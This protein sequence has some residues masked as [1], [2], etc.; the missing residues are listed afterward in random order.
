MRLCIHSTLF[1]VDMVDFEQD[2]K[3]HL[4]SKTPKKHTEIV[5]LA[6]ELLGSPAHS[7]GA[8]P[9]GYAPCDSVISVDSK[10]I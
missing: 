5:L 9:S 6:S 1:F 3:D 2:I 7:P 4:E 10:G 8:R